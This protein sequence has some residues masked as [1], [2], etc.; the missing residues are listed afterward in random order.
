M[1]SKETK[2]NFYLLDNSPHESGDTR[3]R[4]VKARS[5]ELSQGREGNRCLLLPPE[6]CVSKKLAQNVTQ[7]GPEPGVQMWGA[8][9][10]S[11]DSSHWIFF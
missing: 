9:V 11:S 6:V 5:P 2:K 3:G 8:G 4:Q 7:P 1:K 10:L